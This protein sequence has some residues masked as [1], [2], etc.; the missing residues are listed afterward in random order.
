VLAALGVMAI[1]ALVA[2]LTDKSFDRRN[3][4]RG[5]AVRGELPTILRLFIGGVVTL[6]VL[7]AIISPDKFFSLIRQRPAVWAIVMVA[8]PVLSVYPQE[9]LY[10]AYFFHRFAPLFRSRLTMILA[11]AVLFCWAHLLF[12]HWIPLV[13]TLIGGLIFAWRYDRTRSLA[14]VSIE[15]ALYG[16]LIFTIG[17][18]AYFYE[19]TIRATGG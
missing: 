16:Q 14:A 18:G 17:L 9:L 15:H 19:G 10:R 2:L 13:S 1:V 3:L 11:S 8:Y 6:A 7:L 12:Q 4:W 5:S